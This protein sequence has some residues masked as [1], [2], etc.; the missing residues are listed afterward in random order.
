LLLRDGEGLLQPIILFGIEC[1]SGEEFL[2]LADFLRI[3]ARAE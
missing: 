2:K 1:E 3:E